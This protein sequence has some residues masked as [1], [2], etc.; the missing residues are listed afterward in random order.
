MTVYFRTETGDKLIKLGKVLK[1]ETNKI[2]TFIVT[3]DYNEHTVVL[4]LC[5]DEE[6]GQKTFNEII[7]R[8]VS[9]T[10]N[11]VAKE[12]IYIDLG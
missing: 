10:A 9:P 8:I 4:K 7:S 6:I 1:I 5:S 11:E 2:G 3:G 12:I